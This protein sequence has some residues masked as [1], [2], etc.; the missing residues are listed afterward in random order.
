MVGLVWFPQREAD[1]GCGG[2]E[3]SRVQL[4]VGRREWAKDGEGKEGEGRLR[5]TGAGE[6]CCWWAHISHQS[7]AEEPCQGH[8]KVKLW[9]VAFSLPLK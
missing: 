3:G 5:R 1:E 6:P 4:S 7:G 2:W 8:V 9:I